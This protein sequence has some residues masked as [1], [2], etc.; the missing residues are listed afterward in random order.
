[1][2]FYIVPLTQSHTLRGPE[3]GFREWR[4]YFGA[5]HVPYQPFSGAGMLP[6]ASKA[7]TAPNSI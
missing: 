6:D 7:R 5:Q 2:L 4:R 3:P 1:M